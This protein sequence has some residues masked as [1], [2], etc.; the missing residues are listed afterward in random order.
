MTKKHQL[1]SIFGPVIVAGVLALL[2]FALP[3][4]SKSSQATLQKAAVSLSPNVFKNR[5]LKVQ[6]LSDKKDHYIP[7]FGSS[8]FNR[9]D[10]YY[11]ATMAARYHH[12]RP[13]MFGSRGTQSLPQ[14]FNM[15]MMAP[16]MKN[17]KAVFVISPQWFVKKG[18]MLAAFQYY[19]GTYAN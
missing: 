12:Y 10:R 18:V 11:P 1:W 14:L 3:W 8:E 13:F 15:T 4:K 19:N 17:G 16:Q 6:A 5:A 7:F 2:V 9:M